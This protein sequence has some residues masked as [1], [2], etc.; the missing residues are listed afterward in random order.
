MIQFKSLRLSGFKSFADRTEVDI[1]PGLNGIVGPNGCGK[2]NLVEALR[3][4]MG[5]SSARKMRGDG[6]EDVIFNGTSRRASKNIAEVSLLLDN[7]TR[8]APPAYNGTDEIEITRRIEKDHGSAYKINGKTVR[9]RDV[10]MLLA[11]TVTGANSPALVSQ[12]RITHII[13]SKPLE[14][15]IVLEE[16]AGISGLYARRHEAELRLKAADTNLVRLQDIVG[17]MENQLSGLKRQ[18]RQA[19]KYRNVNAQIRQLEIIIA[20]LEW[21]E[22]SARKQAT[23]EK[24]LEAEKIVADKLTT[25]TQLTKTQGTQAQALPDLRKAETEA[26]AALQVKKI[27]L[28]RLEDEASRLEKLIE[29]TKQQL[30]QTVSDEAHES[31]SASES[32]TTL[33]KLTSEESSLIEMQG[34]EQS[35]L[36]EKE[37]IR[38]ELEE[39]VT[40]LESRYTALMQGVAEKKAR[41]EALQ[42]QISQ[43]RTRLDVVQ[44]RRLKAEQEQETRRKDAAA[45]TPAADIQ[46]E[47]ENL[48]E[49]IASLQKSIE[50]LEQQ[51]SAFKSSRDELQASLR[52]LEARLTETQ[53]EIGMLNSF[54]AGEADDDIKTVLDSLSAAPGFEKALSRALGDSLMASLETDSP[55]YWLN[56]KSLSSLPALPE[57]VT[58]IKPSIKAPA[59]LDAALSQIGVVDDEAAGEAAF[60]KLQP[61]QS[62][63]SRDGHYWRWD[64]YCLKAAAR[65]RN[66][67]HLEYKNKL[68]GLEET[69]PALERD[70]AAA[71]ATYDENNQNLSAAETT[72]QTSRSEL[73]TLEREL[74]Q[75]KAA[76]AESRE[77]LNRFE[78]EMQRLGDTIAACKED[79]QSIESAI[80][81]ENA[82]LQAYTEES[83]AADTQ[84]QEEL[85]SALLGARESYQD[86]IRVYERQQQMQ[87]TR[88][89]RLQ[90]IADE[91]I[92][93]K[94]RNI[95]ANERLKVLTERK[96]ELEKKLTELRSQPRSFEDDKQSLLSEISKLE[97]ARND[98][99]EKL[100]VCEKEVFETGKALKEAENYLGEAR[101][102]RAHAQATM[103]ALVEQLEALDI[104]IR[105]K[106]DMPPM[107][108]KDHSSLD[109]DDMETQ[110][111]SACKSS[112]EKLVRERDQI[113]PVNLRADDEA[114]EL[115]QGLTKILT[116]R[117][118]LMQAI[119]ELREGISTINKEARARLMTAFDHVN[120][121]FQN[122]F[123]RLFQGGNAHLALVDSD[124]PLG[125][126]LEIFAQ[127][128]GK[129]L[130]S[131]SL[132]SGG[133]QTMTSI[134]LIFAMFLTNP[135]PIC[136]LD[137]IDAPLD[138]SNVDRLCNLLEEIA[139]RGETRFMIVTHHR[140]TMARMDRL[141]GVTMAERGVSQLVS[142]DLQ[143][144]F[145]FLDKAA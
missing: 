84:A 78:A 89:A 134:A 107:Q 83:G 131:L 27:T 115:E 52:V 108:L 95:R 94:N 21:S 133:E 37:K 72:L 91:R 128:P 14:R 28:Q 79:I 114:Q 116:E 36:E 67:Q 77:K 31:T 8:S 110:D 5:E 118:D 76:H 22:L 127:P 53:T 45:I 64:G 34:N 139:E 51:T 24:F 135:S 26:A 96:S 63:V 104:K 105:E 112:M 2:S 99:A 87:N 66:A 101:E 81:N 88:K 59:Q 44:S 50:D 65:D 125:A 7:A 6:M 16:S 29:D 13:N 102:A 35:V 113:G 121:H 17:G 40:L 140:L 82:A 9:A 137:E 123:M 75:K 80:R 69:L 70:I 98:A 33:E 54:L 56:R 73:K 57:G 144:S 143:Q 25:V 103:A 60:E 42:E 74:T 10:H 126:G 120:A 85:Y 109:A 90:A 19:A 71:R 142:V 111:L 58:A 136:V 132:L 46:S 32:A 4:V 119:E 18:S 93:L 1:G 138:D 141:Y 41:Q 38:A 30:A 12:G 20:W 130:Q 49:K 47:I 106:F 3:W 145:D 97:I 55:A 61:G 124:D 62:I 129:S 48:D 117:N 86:A 100:S 122:L 23:H 43:N 15:R 11:D 92:N 68:A 39:K